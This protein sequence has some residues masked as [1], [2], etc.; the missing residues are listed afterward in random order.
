MTW[1]RTAITVS[2][3]ASAAE[4]AVTT[5][6]S[7]ALPWTCAVILLSAALVL[8][9]TSFSAD[10]TIEPKSRP[11]TSWPADGLRTAVFWVAA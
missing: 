4:M 6:I 10:F 1:S 3:L 9:I 2:R 8:C 5:S 11:A 7:S